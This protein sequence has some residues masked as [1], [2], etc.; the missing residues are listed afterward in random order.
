MSDRGR[1]S[2]VSENSC[3]YRSLRLRRP[4]ACPGSACPG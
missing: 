1:K 3:P 2:H 4:S